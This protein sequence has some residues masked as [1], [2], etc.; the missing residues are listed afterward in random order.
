MSLKHYLQLVRA[1]NVFTAVT[2]VFTGCAAVSAS[3]TNPAAIILLAFSSACL[4]AG[5]VAL[6]DYCDL[7]VDRAERPKRPLPAGQVPPKA[8]V[9]LAVALLAVGVALASFAG[10][11]AAL[12]VE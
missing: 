8:A 10:A 12:W 11:M 1:P 7:E 6:N 4:Y 2:N 9:T 3:A 5:G